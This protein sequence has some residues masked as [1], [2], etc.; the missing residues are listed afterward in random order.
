MSITLRKDL[1]RPLAHAEL[2]GNFEYLDSKI[3]NINQEISDIDNEIAIIETNLDNVYFLRG[4]VDSSVFTSEL[5]G[6]TLVI[7]ED[8]N[9]VEDLS[10]P[11]DASILWMNGT[12]KLYGYV[13][14]QNNMLLG[15]VRI[16]GN[17]QY[18]TYGT[19]QNSAFHSDW[20]TEYDDINDV[21]V[22]KS[23]KS[24]TGCNT[25]RPLP[26]I[27]D[28]DLVTQIGVTDGGGIE[29]KLIIDGNGYRLAINA[30]IFAT[31]SLGNNYS[32]EFRNFKSLNIQDYSFASYIDA[33]TFKDIEL[34]TLANIAFGTSTGTKT[35][36]FDNCVISIS[37]NL[38]L[39]G[40]TTVQFLN[41]DISGGILKYSYT[42][43][44]DIDKSTITSFSIQQAQTGYGCNLN[45]RY[46][47]IHGRI[48]FLDGANTVT[49][50]KCICDITYITGY[51]SPITFNNCHIINSNITDIQTWVNSSSALSLVD[52]TINALPY[53][54]T[55]QLTDSLIKIYRRCN[56]YQVYNTDHQKLVT[57]IN[58]TNY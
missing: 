55:D 49:L 11:V 10:F 6:K 47:T 51:A 24:F 45:I 56:R 22:L 31:S 3:S 20:V 58:G 7:T 13:T 32:M 19:I 40:T 18:H 42:T 15:K 28:R 57:F 52:C 48:M 30:N 23:F 46:S 14:F 38:E 26:F 50:N 29:N 54:V 16:D 2:D 1:D 5:D 34:L 9:I 44:I 12:M 39:Y 43:H 35:V 36:N 21:Y 8:I 17:S 53:V 41:C 37:G 33:I 4:D 25:S 27:L